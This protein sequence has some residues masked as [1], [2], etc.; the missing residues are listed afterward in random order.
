VDP[1][2]RSRAHASTVDLAIARPPV[3]WTDAL[4]SARQPRRT[5]RFES[6]A[7]E[8]RIRSAVAPIWSGIGS[9]PSMPRSTRRSTILDAAA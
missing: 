5:W 9:R 7:H 6:L 1:V 8:L 4:M 3:Y 2:I